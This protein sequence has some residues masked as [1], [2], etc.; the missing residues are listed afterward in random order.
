MIKLKDQIHYKYKEI[1]YGGRVTI[2]SKNPEAVEGIHNF[3]RF[4]ITDHKT[5]DALEVK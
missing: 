5:G 4:Q 3:L 2:A 1:A